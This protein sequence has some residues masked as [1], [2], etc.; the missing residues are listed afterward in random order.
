MMVVVISGDEKGD[1]AMVVMFYE[2]VQTDNA[3]DQI[4]NKNINIDL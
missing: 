4:D 1:I 3:L 2:W